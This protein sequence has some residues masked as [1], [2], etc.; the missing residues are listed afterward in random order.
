MPSPPRHTPH[1]HPHQLQRAPPSLP[2]PSPEVF[3]YRYVCQ[4]LSRVSLCAT[5][6]T[7]AHQ[8]PLSSGIFQARILEWVAIPFSGGSSQPKDQT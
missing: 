1:P 5:P 3:S 6:W 4:S 2:S 8:A 7:V